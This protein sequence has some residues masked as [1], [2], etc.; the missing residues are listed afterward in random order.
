MATWYRTG[1][2]PPNLIEP[3][4]V[5]REM[6]KS[7]VIDGRRRAKRSGYESYYPSFDEAKSA[8][9]SECEHRV[10]IA[11]GRLDRAKNRLSEARKVAQ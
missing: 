3:V 4:E 7:V 1:G 9:V 8:L 11:Q 2:F 10:R 5:E 6:E